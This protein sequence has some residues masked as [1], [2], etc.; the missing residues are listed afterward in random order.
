M[1]DEYVQL[2]EHDFKCLC[3]NDS[4]AW[5]AYYCDL[6]GNELDGPASADDPG[7][8][9]CDNCGRIFDAHTGVVVRERVTGYTYLA[10]GH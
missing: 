8:W 10:T 1:T 7:S 3:G 6:E 4:S 9:C 2:T 5:G